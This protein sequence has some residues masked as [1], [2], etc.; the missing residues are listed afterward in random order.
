MHHIVETAGIAW[1]TVTLLHIGFAAV[2]LV[3]ASVE[4]IVLI[5]SSL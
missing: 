2:H 5:V 1:G 4:R 3:K